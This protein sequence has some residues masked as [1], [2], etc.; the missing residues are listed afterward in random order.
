MRTLAFA[1]AYNGTGRRYVTP[2]SKWLAREVHR[3][4]PTI[5]I[6]TFSDVNKADGYAREFC[7]DVQRTSILEESQRWTNCPLRE[8][9]S[10]TRFYVD[11]EESC[12]KRAA[13]EVKE[14]KTNDEAARNVACR[15]EEETAK[16]EPSQDD[17]RLRS[18]LRDEK[19]INRIETCLSEYYMETVCQKL[20]EN[21]QNAVFHGV[22]FVECNTKLWALIN[23]TNSRPVRVRSTWTRGRDFA[24]RPKLADLNTP[25]PTDPRNSALAELNSLL[26]GVIVVH[27]I[28]K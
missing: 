21:A 2:E 16:T 12:K 17:V 15:E 19:K 20:W 9:A 5:K 14:L 13:R 28:L 23:M 24:A 22:S 11:L 18:F 10:A 7:I 6:M 1:G 8:N 27:E 26:I 3:K 25:D 4:V